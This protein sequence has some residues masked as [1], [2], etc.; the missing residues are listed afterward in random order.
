MCGAYSYR[1][2]QS[3]DVPSLHRR[4]RPHRISAE[5][6]AAESS[7]TEVLPVEVMRTVVAVMAPVVLAA[8]NAVTQSCTA[9]ADAVV[10]WVSDSVVDG[11]S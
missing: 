8:P 1:T 3:P 10:V 5:T 2:L 11:W 9:T 4:S 6:P 7:R